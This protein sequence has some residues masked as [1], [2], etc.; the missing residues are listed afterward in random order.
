[1][2][3]VYI[4]Y[5]TQWRETERLPTKIWNETRM[6]TLALLFNTV[7]EALAIPIRQ[8]N[9]NYPNWKRRGKIFTLCR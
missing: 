8:T 5:N 4:I 3:N 1:M 6:P 9:K 7:L 2:L